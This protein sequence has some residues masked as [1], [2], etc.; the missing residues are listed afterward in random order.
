VYQV[1]GL[2]FAHSQLAG[3]SEVRVTVQA[4]DFRI[5]F[6]GDAQRF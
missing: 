5:H 1:C 2:F 3:C 4:H 6:L